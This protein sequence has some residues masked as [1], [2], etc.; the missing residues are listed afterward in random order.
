MADWETALADNKIFT[1]SFDPAFWREYLKERP[2]VLHHILA[3]LYQI[4]GPKNGRSA[5]LDDLW[6]LVAPKFSDKPFAQAFAD[7]SRGRSV[8]QVAIVVGLS[9]PQI[10]RYLSGERSIVKVHDTEGSMRRLELFAKALSVQPAYF[11]EWRRLWIMSM[12]D[13]V[14]SDKPNVSVGIYRKFSRSD[15]G[16]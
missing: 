8:R 7:A 15:S 16:R 3:D 6:D 10:F 9:H 4:S 12:I 5:N 11:S 2:D 13:S 14:L 1:S